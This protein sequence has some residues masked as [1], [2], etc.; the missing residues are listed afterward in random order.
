MQVSALWA[1][2]AYYAGHHG[3]ASKV[4]L[5]ARPDCRPTPV[6]ESVRV[7]SVA[8]GH[9]TS[10][11]AAAAAFS[12]SD[13]TP[14]GARLP[15]GTRVRFPAAQAFARLEGMEALPAARRDAFAELAVAVFAD[16]PPADPRRLA[17]A[18]RSGSVRE[19][20]RGGGAVTRGDW[21]G[22]GDAW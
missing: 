15:H 12:S 16:R 14:G 13:P 3:Q 6:K 7:E 22:R 19:T 8:A 1:L 9:G 18:G 11:V 21:R 2:T 4:P 20:V 10:P 17:E 5:T